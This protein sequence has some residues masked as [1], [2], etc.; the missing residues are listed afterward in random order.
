V[1]LFINILILITLCACSEDQVAEKNYIIKPDG[2]KVY[3]TEGVEL[4]LLEKDE[5]GN[6][7]NFEGVSFVFK[8]VS[9]LDYLDRV[10]EVPSSQ[11]KIALA[12]ESVFMLEFVG[13]KF[14]GSIFENSEMAKPESEATQ[15]LIG[16][17]EKD[18]TI[19]QGGKRCVAQGVQYDG[20]IGSDQK[21]RVAFFLKGVDLALPY[22]IEYYDRLFG[23]GLVKLTKKK[24]DLII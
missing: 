13:H 7:K 22:T 18:F 1:K 4:T 16:E 15:Y 11:D 2:T 6:V 8:D 23:K 17:I 5:Q 3:R 14:S 19:V 20:K 10:G 9:A 24:T 12:D 21:I